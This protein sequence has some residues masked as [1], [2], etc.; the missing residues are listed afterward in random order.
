VHP[1]TPVLTDD[2]LFV[3]MEPTSPKGGDLRERRSYSLHCRVDDI[4][5]GAG[6]F[7]V[8]GTGAQVLDDTTR[9]LAAGAATYAPAD[10]YVLFAL[11]IDEARAVFYQD[12]GTKVL[13][14]RAS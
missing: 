13:R 11:G 6:E 4:S 9:R 12:A 2:E 7:W 10:R 5:G 14:W 8:S 3:F 1:V